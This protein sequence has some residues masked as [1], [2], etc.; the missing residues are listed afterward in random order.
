MKTAK[1]L[2]APL[3]LL[4]L[5]Q[6]IGVWGQEPQVP[7]E[8]SQKPAVVAFVNVNVVPMDRER[9]LPRQ[10]VI[11]RADRIS[12]IGPADTT[13]IPEGA[14]Q[15]DGSDKYLMPGLADMHVHIWEDYQRTLFIANGVTTVRNMWGAEYALKLRERI[16]KG[17]LIG[18]TIYTAGPLIDGG[19]PIWPTSTVVETSEQAAQVVAEHKKAGYD[20]I[21]VYSRL[22]LECYD[23]IVKAAA[24]HRIPVVGHVPGAVGLERVLAA[25]QY[26][27][28]HLSGY[29]SIL[30]VEDSP[31]WE[32]IDEKR[33]PHIARVTREAG[34]WNCVTLI[35]RQA[36]LVSKGAEQDREFPHMNYVP[37]RIKQRWFERRRYSDPNRRRRVSNRKQM[38]KALHDAG[39][40]ILLGSDTP[41]AYVV[42]GFSLHQ[43]LRIL[44]DAGLTPYEAIKAGT[45]DA[46]ECLGELDEFGTI[47]AGLRADLILI[48]DNPLED[49][50]D[51]ARRIGVM[52]RGRWFPQSDLQA[53]LEA[54]VI[55]HAN[56][57]NP[58]GVMISGRWYPRYELEAMAD[59][60][61]E[62]VDAQNESQREQLV[63]AILSSNRIFVTGRW[64]A[65]RAVAMNLTQ[66]GLQAYVAGDATAQA[67]E[68]GDLLIVISPTH[69]WT[70]TIIYDK[71]SAAKKSGGS[72]LLLTDR[73]PS[74]RT[75]DVADLVFVLGH[76]F[77][78]AVPLFTHKLLTGTTVLLRQGIPVGKMTYDDANDTYT[79]HGAG[80]E[81]WD[82]S[83][84]FHFA[85]HKLNRDGS[86]TARI[87]SVEPIDDW[88]V[89]GLMIRDTT[90]PDSA[91]AAILITPENRVCMYYRS[92]AGGN[93][94]SVETDPDAITLP[95][96]IKLIR[97][98]KTFKAQHSN[99]GKTWKDLKGSSAGIEIEIEMDGVA[100]VGLAVCSEAGPAIA[101]EAK[102]SGVLFGGDWNP[103]GKLTN[104]E[105]IGYELWNKPE[106]TN[107]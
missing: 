7:S 19:P 26:G 5:L 103:S 86:V 104:S 58:D 91:Y 105:D 9:I 18:P 72:V 8:E 16:K 12:E 64:Q 87:D 28:E 62:T 80:N 74:A 94:D 32:Q 69:E 33:I 17:K 52:V 25:N 66:L 4:T 14:L 61:K 40:R 95:H 29:S 48:E 76:D 2:V 60:C 54:L 55:K 24:K 46:A 43:E 42:P 6:D 98:G 36:R 96:W 67:I 20:F 102:I 22:S 50:S 11:V 90:A 59:W 107:E 77:D 73:I 44:V 51:A 84:Q 23:A 35:L 88:T 100:H 70:G 53:M 85:Y 89:A 79:V 21:K 37:P 75:R 92:E 39:A 57:E 3:F 99:D 47:S 30:T 93:T 83:D 56:E 27:V 106:R 78:E 97:Q 38:T 101:A 63:E 68:K 31:S 71:A 81:I 13:D 45:R 65:A 41:N 1:T 15:I 34:T 82:P 49:V 10:T